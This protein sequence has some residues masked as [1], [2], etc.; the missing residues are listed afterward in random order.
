M[1][2][3][4]SVTIE[5]T[6]RKE[7]G[8]TYA[9]KLRKASKVPAVLLENGKCTMLELDSKLLP[10]AWQSQGHQFQLKIGTSVKT[11]TIK[12]LQIH[13]LKRHALHVDLMYV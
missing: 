6:E 5:A 12:E 2:T 1:A 9:R 13:P 10:K 3:D 8:K 11:A 4:T 7:T